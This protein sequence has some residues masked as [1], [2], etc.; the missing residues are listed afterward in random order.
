MESCWNFVSYAHIIVQMMVMGYVLYRFAMPFMQNKKGAVCTGIVYFATM[1]FLYFVPLEINNFAAYG[2]GI[3]TAFLVMYRTDRRNFRQKIFIAVTFFALRWLSVY[4]VDIITEELYRK[5][6]STA[7]MVEH[8]Y[9][10]LAAYIV[11]EILDVAAEAA[12]AGIGAG[13]IVKAYI[14]KNENM[15]LKEMFMLIVPSI[16]GMTG[17]GIMQ[18]YQAYLEISVIEAISGVYHIL[19]FLHFGI[20]IVTIVVMTVLFQNIRARQEEKLQNELLSAQIDST[21]NHIAQVESLYQNIRSIKHDMTNHILTLE[22]L[23]AT[24]NRE[25]AEAYGMELKNILSEMTGEIKSGNPITDVILQEWKMEAEKKGI[26]FCSDYYY[27]KGSRIN[28]FDISVILNNALQNAME[29]VNGDAPYISVHSYHRDN[30]YMIEICNSFTGKLQWD[31]ENELPVTTKRKA[32]G[33]GYGLIN[34]RRVA[35]KYS[36]DIAIDVKDREFCI[37]IMLMMYGG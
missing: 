9:V 20:S 36:G 17:Y 5:I 31:T 22:R 11:M 15:G 37:S 27:P 30:A 10:Q 13:Y 21:E 23:Y 7:Y 29:N 26:C 35:E 32:D 16:T 19:A 24:E 14:Y 18:Y 12:V 33:H 8:P 2:I 3:V 6:I 4:M 28:A 1:L 25:E 34:I